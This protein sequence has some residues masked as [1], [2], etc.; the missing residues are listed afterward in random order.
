MIYLARRRLRLED[1]RTR[2]SISLFHSVQKTYYAVELIAASTK[3]R[4]T[5]AAAARRAAASVR[6]RCRHGTEQQRVRRG[7]S[8]LVRSIRLLFRS[9][10]AIANTL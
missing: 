3:T 7:R 2:T 9:Q 4:A 6:W 1:E 5:A 10:V 8:F